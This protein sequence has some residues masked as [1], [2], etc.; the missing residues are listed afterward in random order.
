MFAEINNEAFWNKVVKISE[1][2]KKCP[3]VNQENTVKS[4]RE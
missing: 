1:C 4:L 2:L 3:K